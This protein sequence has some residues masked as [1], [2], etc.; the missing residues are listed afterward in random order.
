MI[1]DFLTGK[2]L[3]KVKITLSD[4]EQGKDTIH[5]RN[6]V[7]TSYQ[8]IQDPNQE[9]PSIALTLEG[10][11]SHTGSIAAN[12]DG[13]KPPVVSLMIPQPTSSGAQDVS[14]VMTVSKG[15]T[16]LFQDA[17]TGKVIP[18]VEITLDRMGNGSTDT[19]SLTSVLIT[20]IQFVGTED[21]PTV[22]VTLEGLQETIRRS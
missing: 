11:T 1:R 20:S 18:E 10:R 9:E 13:V 7:I 8:L 12:I 17:L 5:L 2:S 19:I 21:I 4:S 16:K 14:L 3:H 15:V 22:K 6:A